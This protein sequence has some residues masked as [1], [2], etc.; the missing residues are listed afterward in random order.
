MQKSFKKLLYTSPKHFSKPVTSLELS[1][2]STLINGQCFFWSPVPEH[3]FKLFSGVFNNYHL[4][5]QETDKGFIEYSEYPENASMNQLLNDYFQLNVD[6]S[7]L[8]DFWSKADNHFL[9]VS[10]LIKGLRVLRQ[11]PLSCLISFLCSQNNNISRITQ[12]LHNLSAKFGS[13]LCKKDDKSYYIF[14]T[15]SQLSKIKEEELKEMGFGYRANYIVESIKKINEKGGLDWLNGLRG[16]MKNEIRKELI[17]LKG[18]GLKVADCIALFSLDCNSAIPV[19]T[20]IWQIYQKTYKKDKKE[21]KLNKENYEKIAEF[22]EQTFIKYP[23]WAHSLIFAADLPEFQV[24]K[25]EKQKKI[26]KKFD[27]DV[28]LETCNVKELVTK[29]IKKK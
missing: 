25:P 22:F 16:K 15:L 1:L 20:H 27:N 10:T 8:I 5:L 11:E 18:I 19:D 21:M 7:D 13:F 28:L 12:M 14:P 2:K 26:K 3:D 6:M 9:E 29:R 24:V 17:E 4:Y 23:G